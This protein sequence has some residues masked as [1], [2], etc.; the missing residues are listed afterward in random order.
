MVAMRGPTWTDGPDGVHRR[1]DTHVFATMQETRTRTT[2]SAGRSAAVVSAVGPTPERRSVSAGT[3]ANIA[4][5]VKFRVAVHCGGSPGG[6]LCSSDLSLHEC[7]T[8]V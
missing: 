2:P 6:T 5:A 7:G 8:R 1:H 3:Y 4:A